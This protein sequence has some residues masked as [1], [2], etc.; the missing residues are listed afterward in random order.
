MEDTS[1]GASNPYTMFD[2][3]SI[4]TGLG[5]QWAYSPFFVRTKLRVS[6]AIALTGRR[7]DDYIIAERQT[8]FQHVPRVTVWHHVYDY[9]QNTGMCT[10]QLVL[11]GDHFSTIPHAGGCSQ[12]AKIHGGKYKASWNDK[13]ACALYHKPTYSKEEIEEFSQRTGLHFSEKLKKFY[14]GEFTLNTK[15]LTFAAQNDFL[16]DA[17]LPLWDQEGASVESVQATLKNLPLTMLQKDMYAIGTSACGD[18]FCADEN[19][20][21][22][23]YDHETGE[24]APTDL[25]LDHL[26]E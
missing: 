5:Q 7:S 14:C 24:Y 3:V 15:A 11:W 6:T 2:V 9:N 12:Y 26:R 22:W 19:G 25:N 23:F 4:P 10:M 16:L 21:I 18:I 13:Q 17:F 8:N 20:V 1:L